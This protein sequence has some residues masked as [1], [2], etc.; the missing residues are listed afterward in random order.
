M[1]SVVRCLRVSLIA[2]ALSLFGTVIITFRYILQTPRPL[3]SVLPG[4]AHLYKWTHGHVFYKVMGTATAPPLVLLHAPGIAASSY[5]MRKITDGLA[6]NYHI[7][8]LDLPGF[9]LSDH[10]KIEYTADTYI[11]VC[12]DFLRDIV[13]Q[14]ATLLASGL[15][16]NY[17]VAVASRAPDLCQRLILLSPVS[18]FRGERRQRWLS[19]LLRIPGLAL[20]L[21]ALLTSRA[22]LR[23]AVA[24]QCGRDARSISNDELDYYYASAHRF[25]AQHATLALLTGT[26]HA[27]VAHQFETLQQPTFIIWGG[28]ALNRTPTLSGQH[29]LPAHPQIALIGSAGARVH[30]EYPDKVVAN[31]LAWQ[32]EDTRVAVGAQARNF[33][34]A[35]NKTATAT[36][37]MASVTSEKA[38]PAPQAPPP[39]PE[40]AQEPPS[41]TEPAA[42]PQLEAES[43]P[44]AEEAPSAQEQVQAYCVKCRQKRA[45]QN[46][47]KIVT[48]KG[49]SAIEGTCPVCGTKL[50]RFV[51]G[52]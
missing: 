2:L 51:S 3:D 8:A 38:A 24:W 21:Y 34:T 26:L 45:I 12:Q 18:L 5:E 16:C 27:D 31:V 40:A 33:L 22:V 9:G 4:D 43:E 50:F 1:R 19:A 13:G 46:P 17:A 10:P 11:R 42:P 29:L 36:N 47:R 49:R 41:E 52:Q 25:G 48:R 6:Q 28:Q 39:V 7:Y 23:R 35:T 15:S 44:E 30:E 37:E 32:A 14:P 20:V